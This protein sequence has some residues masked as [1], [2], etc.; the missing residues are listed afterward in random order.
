MVFPVLYLHLFRICLTDL[1]GFQFSFK[2][3]IALTTILWFRGHTVMQ[4]CHD[5]DLS[6]ENNIASN[7]FIHSSLNLNEVPFYIKNNLL[8][9]WEM[10]L[11]PSCDNFLLDLLCYNKSLLGSITSNVFNVRN[12]TLPIFV[13]Q[14][15]PKHKVGVSCL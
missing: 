2:N 8:L 11:V 5:G 4:R 9:T 6:L 3:T 1:S 15:L 13:R 14:I 12:C 7:V 10:V